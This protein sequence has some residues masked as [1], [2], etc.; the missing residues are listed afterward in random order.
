[1]NFIFYFFN[2]LFLLYFIELLSPKKEKNYIK[3]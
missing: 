1:M 3:Q 2:F